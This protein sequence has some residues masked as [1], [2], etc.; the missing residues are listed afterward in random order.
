MEYMQRFRKE[1]KDMMG[2]VQT[3]LKDSQSRQK[4]WFNQNTCKCSFVIGDLVLVLSPVKKYKMQNLWEAPFEERGVVN[5][6]TY[7]VKK[8][9]GDGVLLLVLVNRLKAYHSRETTVNMISCIDRET[10]AHHHIDL[11]AECQNDST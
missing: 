4:M 11:T 9:H 6:Y 7:Q 2:I 10:E 8:S 1:L 3:N 5:E